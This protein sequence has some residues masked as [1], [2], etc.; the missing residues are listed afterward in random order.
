MT[1]KQTKFVHEYLIDLNATQAAIRAGYST[2][3]AYSIGNENLSKPEI[4]ELI[5]KFQKASQIAN[6]VTKES[7]I[8]DLLAIKDLCQTDMKFASTSI[9][10]IDT[11]TKMLGLNEPTK[12]DITTNGKDI[13]PSINISIIKPKDE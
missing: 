12:T 4:K 1:N 6:Q 3:T 8:N 2:K 7:L 11:I 13:I 5:D 9:K 10:A